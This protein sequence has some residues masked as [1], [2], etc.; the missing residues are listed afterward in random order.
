VSASTATTSTCSRSAEIAVLVRR[1]PVDDA[2]FRGAHRR[3]RWSP[4]TELR[5]FD[6]F[7]RKRPVGPT[8]LRDSLSA[9]EAR[10]RH[11]EPS[12]QRASHDYFA[13]CRARLTAARAQRIRG[14]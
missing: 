11:H 8:A 2:V 3:D 10:K 12:N 9:C 4:I 6:P 1:V 13:S 5:R 14:G 7:A